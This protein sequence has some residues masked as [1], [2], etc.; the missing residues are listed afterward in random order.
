MTYANTRNSD[1]W[2][3]ADTELF[4]KGLALF[5]LDFTLIAQLFPARDRR[6]PLQYTAARVL[7]E[8]YGSF[9]EVA[10]FLSGITVAGHKLRDLIK[11][12][13]DARLCVLC[14]L[15]LLSVAG[16]QAGCLAD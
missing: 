12:S 5:G 15:P 9:E 8:F 13:C 2:M 10:C 1:R 4:Y 7:R 16:R 3:S 14:F 6:V 11:D